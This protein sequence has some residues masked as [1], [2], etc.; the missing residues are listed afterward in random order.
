MLSP[1][2]IQRADDFVGIA[3]PMVP[4]SCACAAPAS[5]ANPSATAA[6]TVLTFSIG[7]LLLAT[8]ILAR[9]LGQHSIFGWASTRDVSSR[10]IAE[11]QRRAERDAGAGV[12]PAHDAGHVVARGIE[13]R[14]RLAAAIERARV[15][16]G[17]DAGI[18]A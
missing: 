3:M 17:F 9:S 8:F 5:V 2:A 18:G 16:V 15:L 7:F 1:S 11:R 6:A 14:D 12:V 10:D 4:L 13:A